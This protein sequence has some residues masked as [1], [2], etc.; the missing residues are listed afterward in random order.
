MEEA[1]IDLLWATT[2]NTW[3]TPTVVDGPWSPLRDI[4][5]Q[6][7]KNRGETDPECPSRSPCSGQEHSDYPFEC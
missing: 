4:V 6:D 7:P 2:P 3:F 1:S 5:Y